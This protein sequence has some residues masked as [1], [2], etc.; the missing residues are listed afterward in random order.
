MV[1]TDDDGG[2]IN[3]AV[4]LRIEEDCY[5]LSPGDG[6]V[7]LW[8]SGVAIA[9]GMHAQVSEPDV[10]PLQL[11]GPKSPHVAR[12]LFGEDILKLRYYRCRDVILDGIP[13]LVSRTGWSGELGFELHLRDARYG[14]QL[15]E[16]VMEAGQPHDI[17]A[18]APNTIRSVEG[19]LLSYG[20]DITRDDNPYVFNYDWMIDF[21]QDRNFIGQQALRKIRKTG[22]ARR[23]VGVELEGDMPEGSNG[24]FWSVVAQG[25]KVG[26]V[27][28]IVHSPR[29]NKNIGY[30]NVPTVLA[31]VGTGLEVITPSGQKKLTVCDW[32]WIPAQKKLP[33]SL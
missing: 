3:D 21:S 14:D 33:E 29:L 15:W 8:V 27:T 4:M 2:I 30:A 6:D 26:R 31:D 9:G 22:P 24:E 11:Q 23:F 13:L 12:D 28:R 5:W 16:K 18:A 7:L 20:S 32:P 25:E 17:S 10:S 1:I 19:G